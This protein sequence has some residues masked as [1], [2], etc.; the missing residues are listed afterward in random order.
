METH[1]KGGICDLCGSILTNKHSLRLHVKK[2][3]RLEYRERRIKAVKRSFVSRSINVPKKKELPVYKCF[4]EG[5]DRHYCVRSH[6][7][8]HIE[9]DHDI[10]V[11]RFETTC[12]EC[13]F[14]CETVGEHAS[15]VKTHT[16]KFICE[17]CKIRF[18]TDES[19]QVHVLKKHRE[20]EHRPFIC[21]QSG[22]GAGFKR[23]AH[24]ESHRINMH[25]DERKLNATFV[26]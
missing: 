19:R 20:G 4:I 8:R 17:Y 21:G 3:S 15:H 7:G 23:T 13:H 2:C 9:R 25:S 18:K 11:P 16:C 12:L 22:C 26:D 5:C 6:L 14:V 24:L 10:K 1:D